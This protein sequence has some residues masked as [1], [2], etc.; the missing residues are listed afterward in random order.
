[1]INTNAHRFAQRRFEI[2]AKK[3]KTKQAKQWT[4]SSPASQI[5]I[6]RSEGQRVYYNN[7]P[8]KIKSYEFYESVD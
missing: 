6:G 8:L 3:I 1:M 7:K 4:A 5:D 2:A